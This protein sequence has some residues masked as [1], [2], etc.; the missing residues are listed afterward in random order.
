MGTVSIALL[1]TL[2]MIRL[3]TTS[4]RYSLINNFT[5][6]CAKPYFNVHIGVILVSTSHYAAIRFCNQFLMCILDCMDKSKRMPEIW[7][8]LNSILKFRCLEIILKN[9][10]KFLF[11]L[12]I[13][14]L[15]RL[16]EGTLHWSLSIKSLMSECDLSEI[17][18]ESIFEI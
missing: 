16:S 14:N 15:I 2:K 9:P 3:V 17:V 6:H 1:S 5:A 7:F 4:L 13:I 10:I 12:D 11:S 18:S 8:S